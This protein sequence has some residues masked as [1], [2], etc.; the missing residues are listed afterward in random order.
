MFQFYCG[1]LSKFPDKIEI[2]LKHKNIIEYYPS[3]MNITISEPNKAELFTSVFKEIKL[4]T[5]DV[6]IMFESERMYIQSMDTSRVMLFEIVFS[7]EWFDKYEQT[8][9]SSLGIS[10]ILL[11]KVLGTRD[12][13]QTIDIQYDNDS[14]NN[15]DKL[16]LQFQS[17][18]RGEF[19][20]HFE[21][22]LMD[23]ESDTLNI[24]E[25]DY[26][27]EIVMDSD[28]FMKL[29]NQFK[30]FGE[31][32]DIQINQDKLLFCAKN[33]ETE[34]MSVEIKT[35]DVDSFCIDEDV[36]TI[37]L[38]FSMKYLQNISKYGKISKKIELKI[39]E[40]QPMKITYFFIDEEHTNKINFFLAPKIGDD[41]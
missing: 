6:N 27:V 38:C 20:K 17:N 36:G 2:K 32:L 3:R 15:S 22:P 11:A 29:M 18:I 12:K 41:D 28:S 26:S 10:S 35:D 5:N 19:T 8:V 40:S 16:S 30:D 33:G 9:S 31:N 21:I 1:T 23:I 4:F 7:K 39:V 37:Q 25:T 34:K 13:H 24:P 14:D